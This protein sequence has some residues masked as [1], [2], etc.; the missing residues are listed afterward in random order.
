M[1]VVMKT[2]SLFILLVVVE[3]VS[4]SIFIPSS[5]IA[6]P[7]IQIAPSRTSCAAPCS[8]FFDAS[9][10][11]STAAAS[12]PFHDLYYEWN[13][14][15]PQS[16]VWSFSGRSRNLAKGPLA[17]HIFE[18]AGNYTVVLHVTDTAGGES[19]AQVG[20]TVADTNT[21][22]AGKTRCLSTSQDFSGCPDGAEQVQSS[23]LS[24]QE[25]WLNAAGGRRLLLRRGSQWSGEMDIRSAGPGMLGSFGTGARPVISSSGTAVGIYADDW[26][27]ADLDLRGS[28]SDQS[29]GVYTRSA[30]GL[31]QRVRA[32]NYM[33]G[34]H[35]SWGDAA[36][37][38]N[39]L[40]ENYSTGARYNIYYG[41]EAT[42][43]LGNDGTIASSH[44]MRTYYVNKMV[45]AHNKFH[46][47]GIHALK[48]HSDNQ[49]ISNIASL[50]VIS[51]NDFRTDGAWSVALGPQDAGSN[52]PLLDIIFERNILRANPNEQ[53]A[54]L[55]WGRFV[56]VKNNLFLATGSRQ[57]YT[58]VA[59]SQRGVE[60]TPENVWV[61]NNLVYKTD[62][63]DEF[64]GISIGEDAS[65]TVV[66]NNLAVTENFTGYQEV[67][68][69]D[70]SSTTTASHNFLRENS[71]D[72]IAPG[73]NNFRL[74]EGSGLI[75]N[76][77]AVPIVFDDF[78][79][80]TRPR[81]SGYDPG[82]HEFGAPPQCADGLDN[83]G[84]DLIDLADPG[85][86]SAED[87][88]ERNDES[89]TPARPSN[90]RLK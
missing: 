43:V 41:G 17:A 84:D 24:A 10:T 34:F 27:V 7:Q 54:L 3:A 1:R 32:E 36:A 9:G 21:V 48:F 71:S 42:A 85:C 46:G 82:P 19:S 74:A 53:I 55:V 62:N 81:G 33:I 52:E 8:I 30:H 61:Y 47:A 56:T 45:I 80:T 51:D 26:R 77:I 70:Q 60:P 57:W 38:R 90:L 13:F 23:D 86:S 11:T 73:S 75:D 66:Q 78:D 79:L 25:T 22:F 59:V 67:V 2:R 16:G 12:R 18:A 37:N 63:G 64:T 39:I 69:R 89:I 76:G 20:I 58:A 4:N 65:N 15:D 6:A 88:D 44:F 14:G 49:A 50:A 83:D 31:V 35:S 5:S 28:G 72:L 87:N 29:I 40:A 68:I